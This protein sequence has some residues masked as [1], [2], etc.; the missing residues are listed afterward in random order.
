MDVLIVD[1][2]LRD[3]EQMAGIALK[4]C[5]KL[6]IA[7]ILDY[8]GVYQ[9]EAG[10]PAMGGEEKRSVA[11]IAE[12]GLKCKVSSWNR[13][14][15]P[16]IIKSMECGVDIIHISVPASDLQIV[17]KLGK[18]REWVLDNLKLCI[19]FCRER[20]FPV[21]VGLEDASRADSS[22]LLKL[23]STASDEGVQR[24]RYADTVGIMTRN[25]VF[26]E[27]SGIINSTNVSVE[28]HAHNDMGMAVANT[29][30]AVKAGASHV[31]CTIGGIGER[32][33]NCDFMKFVMAARVCFGLCKGYNIRSIREAQKEILSIV[34]HGKADREPAFLVPG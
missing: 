26:D 20:G 18:S 2:T 31:D 7:G 19:S 15:I 3:G 5:D 12:M 4:C 27:I 32:A 11:K 17:K 1:T 22:F 21:T 10:V 30:T 34:F 14:N 16:D 28:M 24:V 9:I 6:N 25:R 33:G 8:L 29:L 23:I 13:L